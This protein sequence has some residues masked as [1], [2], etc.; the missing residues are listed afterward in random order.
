VKDANGG[1]LLHIAVLAN[2]KDM[3][4]ILL[5][6]GANPNA[7]DID[8]LSP[9]YWAERTPESEIT[10]MLIKA[11]ADSSAKAVVSRKSQQY[12]FGEF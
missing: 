2:Y 8:G 4:A 11:G 6:F 10:S 12:F 7:A 5:E 3:V 9:L 1:S